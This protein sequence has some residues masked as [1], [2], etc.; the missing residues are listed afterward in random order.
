MG[1]DFKQFRLDK[2]GWFIRD[3]VAACIS[4]GQYDTLS[5]KI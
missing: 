5:M 1:F 4:A 3:L 2:Y